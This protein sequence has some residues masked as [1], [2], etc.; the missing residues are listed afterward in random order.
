MKEKRTG[1]KSNSDRSSRW[2]QEVVYIVKGC[3]WLLENE[4]YRGFVFNRRKENTVSNTMRNL[5]IF[6]F[7]FILSIFC[8]CSLL[9]CLL[10]FLP[11]VADV[12]GIYFLNIICM[13]EEGGKRW[14][15]FY[16]SFHI[17]LR[18]SITALKKY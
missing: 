7:L 5:F 16:Y 1:K 15:Y 18:R 13:D 11:F 6:A 14:P 17:F 8:I 9:C 4:G 10:G 2:C 3:G 12:I